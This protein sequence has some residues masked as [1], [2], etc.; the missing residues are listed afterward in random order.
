[1]LHIMDYETRDNFNSMLLQIVLA[2]GLV[3]VLS[4][5]VLFAVTSPRLRQLFGKRN[6]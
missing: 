5:F 2:L 4:G 1:M 3:T 6:R